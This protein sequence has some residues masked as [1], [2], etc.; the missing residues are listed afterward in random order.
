LVVL[1]ACIRV[2]AG[3]VDRRIG[4]PGYRV[5]AIVGAL[6]S[7]VTYHQAARAFSQCAEIV[8]CTLIAIVAVE[9]VAVVYAPALLLY[10]DVVST[11]VV[12]I[13]VVKETGTSAVS[14]DVEQGADKPVV[15]LRSARQ[16]GQN[17]FPGFGVA[18]VL[19]ALRV[20]G[21]IAYDQGILIERALA[22]LAGYQPVA[23]VL[24]V[25]LSAIFIVG[26]IARVLTRNAFSFLAQVAFS[27][28][29]AVLAVHAG[30]Q[31]VHAAVQTVAGVLSTG[32]FI[33][34]VDFGRF[35]HAVKARVVLRTEVPIAAGRAVGDV[36]HLARP[37]QRVALVRLAWVVGHEADDHRVSGDLTFLGG[38]DHDAVAEIAVIV[39]STI[40]SRITLADIVAGHAL[41][42]RAR[43]SLG[44]DVPVVA[45]HVAHFRV[46]ASGIGVARIRGAP[47]AIVTWNGNPTQAVA[48]E[49][50]FARGTLVAVIAGRPIRGKRLLA[51][52][53][54]RVADRGLAVGVVGSIALDHR[55]RIDD[56][57]G[58]LAD[59]RAVAHIEVV[60]G[61]AVLVRLAVT[62]GLARHAGARDA[63]VPFSTRIFIVTRRTGKRF[64]DT[65]GIGT[66][67]VRR[68]GVVVFANKLL[69]SDTG[70]ILA[71]VLF[72]AGI[73]VVARDVGQ[74]RILT[75]GLRVAA[76][77]CAVVVVVA[78]KCQPLA[79]SALALVVGCAGVV[80]R[81]ERPVRKRLEIAFA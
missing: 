64:E 11:Q 62:H 57:L 72:A 34:T 33:V 55:I 7:V 10:A 45:F 47:V 51:I 16:L 76:V 54:H 79:I 26:A 38:A 58:I 28:S 18:V 4:A 63:L 2:V 66:A 75:P 70:A 17:T 23:E 25:L 31:V 40:F 74:R 3:I 77:L 37:R 13:A 68:A 22:V 81:A 73:V 35:T 41:A 27:T 8:D 71:P 9:I 43:V 56:A 12:V 6:V 44:A 60:K 80:V 48:E 59:V 21:R 61:G 30:Q 14:T 19:H 24:V 49:A 5:A 78:G 32:V 36:R 53:G 20:Q 42:V 69:L 39:G 65:P 46:H 52:S 67:R 29:A 1:S 50:G 15:A